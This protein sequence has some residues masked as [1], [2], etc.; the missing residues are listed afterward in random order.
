MLRVMWLAVVLWCGGMAAAQV[1]TGTSARQPGGDPSQVES[2][3]KQVA[4][5][6]AEI[7]ALQAH[8]AELAR[9]GSSEAT[10]KLGSVDAFVEGTAEKS[11]ARSR[12]D[13]LLMGAKLVGL[14]DAYFSYNAHQPVSGVSTLR[15]F[16]SQTNQFSLNLIELGL[17]KTPTDDA[18]MGY[19]FTLGFGTAMNAVNGA[20]PGGLRFAQYLKEGYA[21]YLSPLGHGLEIDFGKFVTPVGAESIESQNNWN[22]SRG[23][24]FSYGAPFYLFGARAKYEFSDKYSLTGYLVNGWNN[25]VDIYSSGK[26]GGVTFQWR[27]SRKFGMNETWLVGRGA[28]PADTGRRNFSSTVVQ[29]SPSSRLALMANADYGHS[30]QVTG[31][32]RA[33]EWSGL[34]GYARYQ[35]N[36]RY[37]VAARYE[38]YND[39]D[40]F[41]TCEACRSPL[42]QHV[43]E[44]TATVERRFLQRMSTRIEFRHDRSNQPV[45]FRAATPVKD[46]WTLTAGVM[47]TLAPS[48]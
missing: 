7:Q 20:D 9:S 6:K 46:Q 43:Q 5:Q 22:Y 40:G 39:R 12:I 44:W 47:Y 27:P 26:T 45:F 15:S 29:Y 48:R 4:E 41:T 36:P 23:L 35:W 42:P 3:K 10:P 16:D 30:S 38:Y 17:V 1:T 8:I 25:V 21:S 2:L 33:V 18:R 19:N 14:M 32:S 11:D 24:L 34:A 28:T 13:G 37:S 31:F